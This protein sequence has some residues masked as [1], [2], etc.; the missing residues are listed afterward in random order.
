VQINWKRGTNL[1]LVLNVRY[2]IL[3]AVCLVK[4]KSELLKQVCLATALIFPAVAAIHAVI[5]AALHNDG[6]S[7]GPSCSG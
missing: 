6:R 4:N 3:V 5:L 2:Y 7:F 1:C